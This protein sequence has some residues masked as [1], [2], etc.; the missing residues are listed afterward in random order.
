V[1]QS[2][3]TGQAAGQPGMASW[4]LNTVYGEHVLAWGKT[5]SGANFSYDYVNGQTSPPTAAPDQTTRCDLHVDPLRRVGL[6][7]IFS[8]NQKCYGNWGWQKVRGQA[9]RSAWSGMRGYGHDWFSTLTRRQFTYKW[10]QRRCN[11]RNGGFYD[12][13]SMGQGFA[14]NMGWSPVL[15]P[16]PLIPHEPCGPWPPAG[17]AGA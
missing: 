15:S 2:D 1:N 9:L 6:S 12:Y 5:A 11:R 16:Y 10:L 7:F 14:S 13:G 3:P 8:V 4:A 17:T